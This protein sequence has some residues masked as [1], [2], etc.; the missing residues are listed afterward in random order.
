[1]ANRKFLEAGGKKPEER[2]RARA[3]QFGGA[4][5]GGA[6]ALSGLAM[7]QAQVAASP[8]VRQLEALQSLADRE[9]GTLQSAPEQDALLLGRS[10]P[11]ALATA[12][13]T[14][15][16]REAAGGLPRQLRAGIE[17]LSGVSM[18]GVKV[19]RDSQ[20]PARVGAQAFAHGREIHLAP[21]Q[22][23]HLPH[24]AWH[25]VQQA[26]GRVRPTAEVNGAMVNDDP[27]LEA[28]ADRM[29]A[30][31]ETGAG[32]SRMRAAA[33]VGAGHSSGLQR[34]AAAGVLQLQQTDVCL[35]SAS[36][37]YTTP[38]NDTPTAF[39][40]RQGSKGSDVMTTTKSHPNKQSDQQALAERYLKK[41]GEIPRDATV[42]F[43]SCVTYGIKK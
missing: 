24:E 42:T 20:A 26:Q 21:G 17:G 12:D 35:R 33:T 40:F 3:G 7:L 5:Q 28:E 4:V 29:G 41:V 19:H 16:A 22:E 1:M 8:S 15:P 13:G 2:V 30:R 27:S 36:G 25:V 18:A 32:P 23:R 6:K 14:R 11:G 34:K 37:T 9:S 31:A 10:G 39:D 43:T 38:E